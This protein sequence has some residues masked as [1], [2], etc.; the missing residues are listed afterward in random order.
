M[1]HRVC[2]LKDFP[3][4]P[5]GEGPFRKVAIVDTE[6]TGTDP[7]T[8]EIIDIAVV[9]LEV[10]AEGEIVGIIS[11]VQRALARISGRAFCR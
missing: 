2:P 6:T 7:Q 5:R 11:A 3:L 9:M 1:L 4:A 8:D 10:D